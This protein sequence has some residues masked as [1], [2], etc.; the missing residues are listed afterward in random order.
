[1]TKD[2]KMARVLVAFSSG[3]EHESK[4]LNDLIQAKLGDSFDLTSIKGILADDITLEDEIWTCSCVVLVSSKQSCELIKNKDKEKG[5]GGIVIFDGELIYK[6]IEE[7]NLLDKTVVVGLGTSGSTPEGV[8]Q[9]KLV[10][11]DG[12]MNSTNPKIDQIVDIIRGI[13]SSKVS[14]KQDKTGKQK[15]KEKCCQM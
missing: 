13:V 1:M 11:L 7:N 3:D 9:N 15:K 8:D 12:E 2:I 10:I 4:T 14:E 6:H 5:C